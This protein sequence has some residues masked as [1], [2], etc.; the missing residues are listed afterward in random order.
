MFKLFRKGKKIQ[1]EDYAA[2]DKHYQIPLIQR[3]DKNICLS[4]DENNET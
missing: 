2:K 3:G 1:N 4:P